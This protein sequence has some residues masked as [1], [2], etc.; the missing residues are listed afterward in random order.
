MRS[1][2]GGIRLA[3]GFQS[4]PRRE[5]FSCRFA[6]ERS[7]VRAF[8]LKARLSRLSK[9]SGAG[10]AGVSKPSRWETTSPPV[11]CFKTIDFYY[12]W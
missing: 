9:Q 12:R 7:L 2:L 3:R 5:R 1:T 8:F 6:L 4:T 11:S 10:G